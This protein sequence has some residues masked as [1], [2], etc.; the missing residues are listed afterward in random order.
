MVLL[1][2]NDRVATGVEELDFELLVVFVE[3]MEVV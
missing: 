2:I 3:V 1:S